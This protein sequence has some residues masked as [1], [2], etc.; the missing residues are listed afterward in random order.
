MIRPISLHD[1]WEHD[2]A[3]EYDI[4]EKAVYRNH[5]RGEGSF[6][7]VFEAWSAEDLYLQI[8]VEPLPVR[9]LLELT[10]A[11]G[12]PGG[13]EEW[14]KLEGEGPEGETFFSDTV[15]IRRA[16]FGTEDS[17]VAVSATR[18]RVSI[19]MQTSAPKPRMRLWLR[20]SNHSTHLWS[21]PGLDICRLVA[22]A[23]SR[24]RRGVRVDHGAGH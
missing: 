23:R 3:S 17:R 8:E 13:Y 18:A 20:A 11:M 15:G 12:E 6:P 10:G 9:T 7:V 16:H 24:K 1:I 14:L 5:T 2:L 22:P 4:R 21:R 19:K